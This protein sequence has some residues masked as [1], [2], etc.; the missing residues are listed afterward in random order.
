MPNNEKINRREFLLATSAAAVGA[1]ALQGTKASEAGRPSSFESEAG[2]LIPYSRSELFSYRRIP[3][4]I[5]SGSFLGPVRGFRGTFCCPRD[6]MPVVRVRIFAH[7][8]KS[9]LFSVPRNSE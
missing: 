8:T 6:Q 4:L 1:T 9:Q 5:Q 7:L 2:S 3:K